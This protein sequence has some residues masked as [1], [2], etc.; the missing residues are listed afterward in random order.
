MFLNF[1]LASIFFLAAPFIALVVGF[2]GRRLRKI[3]S[4]IQT[5]MGDVT[6]VASETISAY[7]EVKAFG[8]KDYEV[9]RFFK[10]SDN[11]RVQNLKLEATNALA[12][13]SNTVVSFSSFGFN[14]LACA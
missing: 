12:S 13:P 7:K 11:N 14:N 6:H 1:K 5:A 3:S 4:R 2:A 10:A 9:N 8:G